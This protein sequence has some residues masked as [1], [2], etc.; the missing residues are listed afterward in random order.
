MRIIYLFLYLIF[1]IGFFG[2]LESNFLCSLYILDIS[3]LSDVGLV[4]I[5]SQ[6][7]GCWLNNFYSQVTTF[8]SDQTMIYFTTLSSLENRVS[9]KLKSLMRFHKLLSSAYVFIL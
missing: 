2:Y 5:F 9:R 1:K 3:S 7:V 4:M 6:S 8:A